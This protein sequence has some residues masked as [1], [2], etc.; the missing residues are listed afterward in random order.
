MRAGRACA[1][2]FALGSLATLRTAEAASDDWTWKER[3]ASGAAVEI[4]NVNGE[5][6]IE[7]SKDADVQV[8]AVKTARKSN[9]AE[10]K[11]EVVKHAGGVTICAIYPS[12]PGDP[13][14]S[15][16]PGGGGRMNV[17]KGNDVNVA[18]TVKMPPGLRL[19]GKTVNG[20]IRSTATNGEADVK[21]VNGSIEVGAIGAVRAQTVNGSVKAKMDR[22]DWKGEIHIA[23]VNGSVTIDLPATA[24]ADVKAS[25]VN[26]AIETDFGLPVEGKWGPKTLSGKIGAGGRTLSVNTVNGSI[27]L[28][29]HGG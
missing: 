28:L 9:P 10:V 29:R 21:T 12:A 13:P 3:L 16:A 7:D 2:V 23:T 17:P 8:N 22:T 4:R 18:F 6:A 20:A 1:F 11:I 24:S 15:C 14:N 25:T 26:G 5:I 19:I 27:K